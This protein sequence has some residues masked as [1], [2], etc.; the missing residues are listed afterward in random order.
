MAL[1]LLLFGNSNT[2]AQT[3]PDNTST[4][5]VQSQSGVPNQEIKCKAGFQLLVRSE[6]SM[7]ACLRPDTAQKLIERGWGHAPTVRK[8]ENPKDLFA[9]VAVDPVTSRVYAAD[10]LGRSLYVLDASTNRTLDV[11]PINGNPWDVAVNQVT[12]KVYVVNRNSPDAVVVINGSTDRM[13]GVIKIT[14]MGAHTPQVTYNPIRIQPRFYKIEPLEVAVNPSTNKVYVS[15]WNY[16]DGGITVIDGRTDRVVKT[17]LGL[18]GS[19]YGIGVNPITNRVYIDEFQDDHHHVPYYV[20]VIDGS[21]DSIMANVT[22]GRTG[23]GGISTIPDSLRIVP[24]AVNP[25]SNTIYAVCGGCRWPGQDH[26]SDWISIINGT[27]NEVIGNYTVSPKSIAVNTEENKVYVGVAGY[28]DFSRNL[29]VSG[30]HDIDVLDGKTN[31]KVGELRSDT[32]I[33][34]LAVNPKTDTIYVTNEYPKSSIE[35]LSGTLN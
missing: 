5:L 21:T 33:F 9:A 4:P 35:M 28:V 7:P 12:G 24:L 16:P 18:G 31:R 1:I 8:Q 14:D 27:T 23:P 11:I 17:I 22:I 15:D 20:T 34:S 25:A 19:S 26:N 32:V 13:I 29:V 10:Y 30:S 6:G 2:Q 3:P